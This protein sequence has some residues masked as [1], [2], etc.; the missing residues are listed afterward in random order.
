MYTRLPASV[1]DTKEQ[2]LAIITYLKCHRR[3]DTDV[4][5]CCRHSDPLRKAT[6]VSHV[7]FSN[8]YYDMDRFP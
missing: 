8:S 4:L 6:F 2:L 1:S 5:F 7:Y 3:S